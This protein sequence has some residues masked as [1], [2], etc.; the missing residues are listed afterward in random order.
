[1][2]AVHLKQKKS[3][4]GGVTGTPGP[5]PPRYALARTLLRVKL[6]RVLPKV[7]F[8]GYGWLRLKAVPLLFQEGYMKGKNFHDL[9]YEKGR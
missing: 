1:M 8:R 2:Y 9:E 4:N 5:P 6:R 3:P 7:D